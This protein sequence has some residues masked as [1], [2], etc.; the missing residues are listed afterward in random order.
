MKSPKLDRLIRPTESRCTDIFKVDC[1]GVECG[2]CPLGSSTTSENI[3]NWLREQ[4]CDPGD[5]DLSKVKV[6]DWIYVLFKGWLKVIAIGDWRWPVKLKDYSLTL[7]GKLL[8]NHLHPVAWVTPPAYLNAPPKPK[9]EPEPEFKKGDR[10]LV[11][12]SK[13]DKWTRK[14]FSHYLSSSNM[15]YH[16]FKMGKDEWASEGET[17]G[18]KYC[19]KWK[20]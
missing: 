2:E 6:G 18:W 10:V 11:R 9:P 12:D 8:T 16:C 7:D 20:E 13:N 17:T 19:K 14:Y 15:P 5:S 4:L 1:L 3:T